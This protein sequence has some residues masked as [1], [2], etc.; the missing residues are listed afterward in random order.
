MSPY[1]RDCRYD[2][3]KATGEDACPFTTLY[4]D[5]LDRHRKQFSDNQRM[6][7]Q[8]KNLER[9]E[10]DE[11]KAIRKRARELRERIDEGRRVR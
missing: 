4:W 9:K 10:D 11:L 6:N 2:H 5:F 3:K 7:F 8:M 1:C